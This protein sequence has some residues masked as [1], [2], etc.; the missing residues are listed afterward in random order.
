MNWID[1]GLRDQPI[2][3]KS[4]KIS[5]WSD[6][7]KDELGVGYRSF[8]ATSLGNQ[9]VDSRDDKDVIDAIGRL[10]YS[11]DYLEK[12]EEINKEIMQQSDPLKALNAIQKQLVYFFIA[13]EQ[14]RELYKKGLE[15]DKKRVEEWRNN[16]DLFSGEEKVYP[17]LAKR[18]N[19]NQK[20]M[21][22]FTIDELRKAL[23][24]KIPD[25]KEV[26]KRQNHDW[27][28]MLKDGKIKLFFKDLSPIGN[29]I[30]NTSVIKG[31]SVFKS[32]QKIIGFVGRNILVTSM[33]HPDMVAEMKKM[34]AIITDEGGI[35]SHVAI[36]CR[37]FKIPAIIGTKIA[38]KIL[39]EGD[40][41]ELDLIKGIISVIK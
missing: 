4:M 28:L 36:T 30:N 6:S 34:K 18:L 1:F 12:T 11:F 32:D 10:P 25:L 13:N 21:E 39:K 26:R 40:R 14:T 19:L 37:E 8:I 17:E 7:L 38:T 22:C 3:Q 15:D 23:D 33:T 20:L 29:S 9:F 5:A 24:G 41:V 35:L 31:T 27:S 16:K 2:L